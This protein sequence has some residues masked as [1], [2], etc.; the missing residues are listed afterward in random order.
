MRFFPPSDAA[1]AEDK[2]CK[3]FSGAGS[4]FDDKMLLVLKCARRNSLGASLSARPG[5]HMLRDY[6][7]SN[8]SHRRH[9]RS[10]LVPFHVWKKIHFIDYKYCFLLQIVFL[11]F[12]FWQEQMALRPSPQRQE[13]LFNTLKSKT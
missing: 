3:S 2:I 13:S 4:G 7:L 6:G 9:Y 12:A 1:F 10:D 11:L 5:I 8:R